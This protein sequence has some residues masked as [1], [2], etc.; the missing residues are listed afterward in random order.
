MQVLGTNETRSSTK[1]KLRRISGFLQPPTRVG[2]GETGHELQAQG[3][4]YIRWSCPD[5][6][7]SISIDLKDAPNQLESWARFLTSSDPQE[8]A[9]LKGLD[10]MIQKAE[11]Q[12]EELSA[13]PEVRRRAE[14][15]HLADMS[16]VIEKSAIISESRRQGPY[17]RH[18]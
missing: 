18:R 17:R 4:S 6:A 10:P 3:T 7:L 12:L 16:W 9:A 15:R 5:S 1:G 2:G 8:V 13:E 11:E 14:E